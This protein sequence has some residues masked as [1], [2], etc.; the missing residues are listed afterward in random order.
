MTTLD[1]QFCGLRFL[2]TGGAGMIGSHLVKRLARGGAVVHVIDNLWRG[3]LENL[4]A[5]GLPV[6]DLEH[7]FV[8][9]D[10]SDESVA[11]KLVRGYDTVFHLA[12]VVG[13]INYVFD[14]Q[15]S[16]FTANI[17]IDRN[18]LRA[19]ITH[20]VP[21]YVYVGSACSYPRE[22][23]ALRNPP[24]L[25]EE[26]A[27]PANPESA[28]GWSKLMGEYM[29][30]L[31]QQE[32]LVRVGILRLHNVYGPSAEL[33]PG[34]SQVIPALIRKALRYPDEP[35]VVWGS[36]TQRRSFVF[37]EDAVEA[38]LRTRT[39][40]M[41]AGVVQFGTDHS[42]AIAEI[43]ERVVALSGR[44]IPIVYDRGRPEGDVDRYPCLDRAREVLDYQPRI[45]LDEGLR[46]TLEWAREKLARDG[47]LRLA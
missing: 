47:I 44:E 15:L 35:F 26:D 14:H 1:Q 37:V 2:V 33:S 13:G 22:K 16:L 43:A 31:A 28:Y 40:G 25:R 42:V 6:I 34:R 21:N 36:G 46:R 8:Q 29:A 18:V 19:C 38:L 27:R 9:A 4:S 11:M 39:R 23:Q 45:G 7:E 30:E 17:A 41:C 32:G 12:D 24:P 20:G 10:L 3:N 5:G